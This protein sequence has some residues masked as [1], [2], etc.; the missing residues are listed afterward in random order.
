[1]NNITVTSFF[2][3]FA[4]AASIVAMTPAAF[5]DHSE[6]TI[7][8]AIGSGTPGCEDTPEGCYIPSTAIVDVGGKVIMSNTDNQH[9]HSHLELQ[10]M[11]QLVNLIQDC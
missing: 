4:I 1:M 2:V 6:V 5:A 10:V 8:T 11:V 3:L 7:E 9:I